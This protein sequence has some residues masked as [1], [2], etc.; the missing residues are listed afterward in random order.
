M[1]AHYGLCM[2]LVIFL[3]HVWYGVSLEWIGIEM[4]FL[5]LAVT[6]RAY[7][8]TLGPDRNGI[9][10]SSET[11]DAFARTQ[12]VVRHVQRRIIRS[13]PMIHDA[14]TLFPLTR[15]CTSCCRIFYCRYRSFLRNTG[16][17]QEELARYG[18]LSTCLV[19]LALEHWFISSWWRAGLPLEVIFRCVFVDCSLFI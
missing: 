12:V 10:G 19:V 17:S 9:R 16:Y 4:S 13:Q 8:S 11:D 1:F 5:D 7:L 14:G 15:L 6:C 18:W 2:H 3:F